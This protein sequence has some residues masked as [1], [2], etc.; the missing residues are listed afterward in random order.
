MIDASPFSSLD[1]ATSFSR[2]LWFKES[3]IQSWLDAFSGHK[4]LTR[5]IRHAPASMIKE[6]HQWDRRYIAKFRFEFTTSTD[7]CFSQKIL[8][9]VKA[10]YENTLVVELDIAAREEFKLIEH[11]LARLWERKKD[12]FLAV[13]VIRL[14]LGEVVPDSMEKD[15]IVSS[16]GF[17]EADSTGRETSI[18]SYDL[19]KMPKE[20]EYPYSG[21]S[22]EKKNAWHLAIEGIIKKNI[23]KS[24]E[25]PWKE[26]RLRL[27]N[28]FYKPTFMTEQNNEHRQ[29]G[30]D[31][32]H[33]RWFLDYRAK[34][35]TKVFEKEKPG[36]VRGVGFGPTPTQLFGPNSHAPGNGVQ[37]EETQRKLIELQAELEG[38]K[39]KRKVME[40]EAAVE[41]KR[42]KAMESALIYLFQRQGE[43][44]PLDI[45]AGMSFV[46]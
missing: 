22:L 13:D 35:E 44:L 2:E 30:I 6:L 36:R 24:M 46:E 41:K 20:N 5:A 19:N 10:R 7:T 29:P 25:K 33:W 31:R 12:N 4:H 34:A 23:L 17:D 16:Y 21:M 45:A 11:G 32:E 39:L 15:D 28:A 9:E 3:R 37:L 8:D 26:T 40:D 42:M 14:Y 43:E 18:L 38:E 27:Y 1:H